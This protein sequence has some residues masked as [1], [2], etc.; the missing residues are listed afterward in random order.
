MNGEKIKILGYT[1]VYHSK[2]VKLPDFQPT[3]NH[4]KDIKRPKWT[5]KKKINLCLIT[6]I[7]VL[8]LVIGSLTPVYIGKPGNLNLIII[9]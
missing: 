6:C 4:L 3:I 1:Y 2:D 8:V 5:L 9:F 7:A